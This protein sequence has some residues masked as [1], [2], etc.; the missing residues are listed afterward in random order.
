MSNPWNPNVLVAQLSTQP[1][2]QMGQNVSFAEME[3]RRRRRGCKY[4]RTSAGTC[5]KRRR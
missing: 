1:V 2:V 5:R 3:A 4:G